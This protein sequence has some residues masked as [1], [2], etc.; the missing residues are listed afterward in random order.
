[1][2]RLDAHTVNLS[3]SSGSSRM[4]SREVAVSMRW[5]SPSWRRA[6]FRMFLASHSADAR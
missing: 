1:M 6:R 3:M 5:P 2:L 4:R